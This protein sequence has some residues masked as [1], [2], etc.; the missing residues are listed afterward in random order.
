MRR[1]H[2]AQLGTH[3]N[4]TK[5]GPRYL[6]GAFC[7]GG[8]LQGGS[9]VGSHHFRG[10][11]RHGVCG[12]VCGQGQ[13]G[14]NLCRGNVVIAKAIFPPSQGGFQGL[15]RTAGVPFGLL[16][17]IVLQGTGHSNQTAARVLAPG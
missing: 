15:D 2:A 11:F 9:I 3:C 7:I 4:G 17:S 13:Q 16:C 5:K 8:L 6:P 14:G 10:H 1:H 12:N